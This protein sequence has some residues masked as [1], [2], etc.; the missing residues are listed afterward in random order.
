MSVPVHGEA[1]AE[2]DVEFQIWDVQNVEVR[3]ITVMVG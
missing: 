2:G 3:S 1:A